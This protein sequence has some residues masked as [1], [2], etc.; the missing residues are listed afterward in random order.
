MLFYQQSLLVLAATAF[1][2]AAFSFNGGIAHSARS[3]FKP[4][5]LRVASVEESNDVGSSNEIKMVPDMEAYAAGYSTV[6]EEVPFEV[7]EPTMG[8]IPSDLLGTYFRSGPA[9]FSAGSIVPPKKSLVQPKQQP[10]PDGSDQDRMVKHPFDGDGACLG[11]TF[12]G[13]GKATSRY[14]F[15]R[16]T[17]LT[18]ERKKG[19]KLYSGMETTRLGGAGVA[20]GHGND[21]PV[22][23]YKHHLQPGL[24]KSRKNT[25]NTRSVYWSKKLITLWEGGLPYK[26]DALG[27]STEGR[28]QLGGVLGEADPFSGKAVFDPVKDRMLFYSNKQDGG[29]SEL[30]LYEFNSKFRVASANEYKLPGFAVLSDFAA[31]EKYAIFVQPPISTNG[32]KFMISKEPSKS[33]KLDGGASMF[34]VLKRGSEGVMKTLSIP[35]DNMSDAD[36]HFCNAYEEDD[37]KT[38]VVDAIRSDTSGVSATQTQWPWA[39]SM[40]EFAASSSKK[41]L[42]RYTMKPSTGTVT[43]ELITDVPTYFATINPTKNGQSYNYVYAAVGAMGSENAP[44]QGIAKINVDTKTID[45]WF[46]KEYEFCGEPMFAQ[47]KSDASNGEEDDGYIISILL[48][49]KEKKSEIVILDAAKISEGPVARVPLGVAIPHGLHGCFAS[50]DECQ[51][52]A[53]EV[54][55]RAKLADKME[56]RD[57]MWN[58]V[59]SDFSGLGLR[60]DD[61]EEYFGDI[62]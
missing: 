2:A 38:L 58:E 11:V 13:D 3:E 61:F 1:S 27:L 14:R 51:W 57:H 22:P 54:E 53:E 29:G 50:S 40:K 16:T 24:N 60:L 62:L 5:A 31:T 25:S 59:K 4:T 41:S 35:V 47:R 23:L 28:S 33:L 49:G 45:T 30:T 8:S 42:W 15:V 9:M 36:L 7:S 21:F 39:S 34:Q 55:R 56:A 48:N 52:S 32:M 44:P 43:K 20:N 10:V 12:A 6:F 37:G 18:K 46:P 26:L 19:K 17:A